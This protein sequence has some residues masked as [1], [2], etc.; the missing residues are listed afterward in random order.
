MKQKQSKTIRRSKEKGVALLFSLGILGLMTVLALTFSSVSMTN[1][2]IAE[3]NIHKQFAK[4]YSKSLVSRIRYATAEYINPASP[5][6]GFTIKS[7]NLPRYFS[8]GPDRHFDHIWKLGL[9]GTS[10]E[11]ALFNVDFQG[12]FAYDTNANPTWQYIKNADADNEIVARYAYKVI[13]ADRPLADLSTMLFAKKEPLKES[14]TEKRNPGTLLDYQRAGL[15]PEELNP[16]V[17]WSAIASPTAYASLFNANISKL[18]NQLFS[19]YEQLDPFINKTITNSTDI[20]EKLEKFSSVIIN[21]AFS[22]GTRKFP[23]MFVSQSDRTKQ[24]HR[25]NIYKLFKDLEG[26]KPD[27]P[28]RQAIV[29]RMINAGMM[30]EY[31]ADKVTDNSLP[32]L[33]EFENPADNPNQNKQIAANIVDFF[34]ESTE[35]TS[36]LT[37]ADWSKAVENNTAPEYTGLKK[38]SYISGVG[39]DI[40][41]DAT[42]EVTPITDTSNFT[43]KYDITITATPIV[44]I[45]NMYDGVPTETLTAT[46]NGDL[47]FTVNLYQDNTDAA[48]VV[49]TLDMKL[50]DTGK[51]NGFQVVTM[52]SSSSGPD[53]YRAK[54]LSLKPFTFEAQL[55]EYSFEDADN[56]LKPLYY[57]IKN[58][59]FKPQ[60]VSLNYVG[61]ESASAGVDFAVIDATDTTGKVDDPTTGSKLEITATEAFN[62]SPATIAYRVSDPRHNLLSNA[63]TRYNKY[64]DGGFWA[65]AEIPT[66]T[67]TI[68]QVSTGSDTAYKDIYKNSED[69]YD[70]LSAPTYLP[71][72]A[73]KTPWELGAIHRGEPWRTLNLLTYNNAL[74]QGL[75]GTTYDKGDANLLDQIKLTDE[76]VQYGKININELSGNINGTPGKNMRIIDALLKNVTSVAVADGDPKDTALT[77][78]GNKLLFTPSDTTVADNLFGVKTALATALDNRK[79]TG[80]ITDRYFVF[81]SEIL[82]DANVKEAFKNHQK[83]DAGQEELF[84]KTVMLLDT[85][86]TW[87]PRRIYIIG[88][89]QVIKDLGPATGSPLPFYKDWNQS[90]SFS[91]NAKLGIGLYSAGYQYPEATS[92]PSNQMTNAPT[93]SG[94]INAQKGQYD[95][96]ADQIL[97]E[98]KVFAILE[99]DYNSK[100][101]NIVR[102][103]YVD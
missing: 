35:P 81:R 12:A 63:W 65:T 14:A 42:Q 52:E 7:Q 75:G 47:T 86:Q 77:E 6:D 51:V 101:W 38:T 67:N 9:S 102:F 39:V 2:T 76:T 48:P 18:E 87:L 17:L 25:F 59:V 29:N 62:G 95:N 19:N 15:V 82:S 37:D 94:T 53:S 40:K 3:N 41:L 85:E 68:D 30:K 73:M 79:N 24:Y 1:K 78:T 22:E 74:R 83:D 72:K 23:E 4:T 58:I 55:G 33:A 16:N 31:T 5:T 96:G 11:S 49:K 70:P 45:I 103:E 10:I 91:E 66:L 64:T 21:D 32:W 100:T 13:A 43:H 56:V 98:Q 99:R 20:K 36:N 84:L 28:S 93:V 69:P 88:L 27:L 57:E 44:E 50:S 8:S 89:V 46:L 34:T 90:G 92:S 26:T 61:G 71:Q 80:A 97:A 60:K 54:L